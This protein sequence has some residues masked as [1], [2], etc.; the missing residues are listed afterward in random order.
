M[1]N[2]NVLSVEA[3]NSMVARL[4]AIIPGVEFEYIVRC[5]VS[6]ENELL[7]YTNYGRILN[8]GKLPAGELTE[9]YFQTFVEYINTNPGLL[10]VQNSVMTV[11]FHEEDGVVLPSKTIDQIKQAVADGQTVICEYATEGR[12]FRGT[13]LYHSEEAFVFSVKDWEGKEVFFQ[14]NADGSL[15]YDERI[16]AELFVVRFTEQ[17]G[18]YTADKTFAEAK[19]AF[20]E[21]NVVVADWTNLKLRGQ[22]TGYANDLL[23]F[24]FHSFL[25]ADEYLIL[26]AD[27]TIT[28]LV[29]EVGKEKVPSRVIVNKT[30]TALQVTATVDGVDQV[31]TI[32]L[33]ED[34]DPVSVTKGGKTTTLT[35]E[36]FDE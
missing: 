17:N 8:A 25:G 10:D 14:I 4:N 35:W 24:T 21:G 26:S 3:E 22:L 13:L 19:A 6:E 20:D 2:H 9:N 28:H 30:D 29:S 16:A 32:A 11:V 15:N 34:G 27:G 5:E 31:T 18:T 1:T 36:G 12:R 23:E 33:N 7:L